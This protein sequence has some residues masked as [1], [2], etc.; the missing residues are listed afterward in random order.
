MRGWLLMVAAQAA[1][2]AAPALTE[3]KPRG[4]EIG[5]PFTLTVIGRNLIEGATVTSTLPAAFTPVLTPQSPGSMMYGPGRTASFLVEL[6]ADAAPGVYPIRVETPSGLSN[7]LLF[8]L[9]TYPETQEEESAVGSPPHRNDSIETAEPVRSTPVVVNGTLRGAERDVFRVYGKAGERRVFEVEAR[10][11]GSAVDPV[12]RILDGTGKQ[13]AR[14]DDSPGASLDARLDFAFPAEGNYYVEIADARFS[15]QAH[16]FYRLKMGSYRYAEGI[17][18][19]GG[20]RGEQTQVTFFGTKLGTAQAVADLRAPSATDAFGKVALPDSPALPFVFAIGDYPEVREPL[21]KAAAIP[22]TINGRLD[23]AGEVDRYKLAVEP[24]DKLILEMQARELGTSKIEAILTAYDAA[25]KKLGSAGDQPL[26]EDVFAVQNSSRTS[27]DP[28]LNI[29]VPPDV[30]ELTVTVEDLALRGGP[31]YGYRLSARKQ[32]EDFKLTI[33]TPQVN[34]PAGGS[35]LVVATAD[36]RGFDGPIQLTVANPPKGIQVEGGFIPREYLDASNQRT[37]NRRGIL[38]ITADSDTKLDTAQLE[39]WGEGR[40]SDGAVLKRRARGIGMSLDVA[41]AT[42]QGVVDRQRSLTAPWLGLDLPVA[43][44]EQPSATLAVRQT[45][46]KPMEEGVRYEYAWEWTIRGSLTPPRSV[47]VEVP[48]AKDLR[49]IDMKAEK[50]GGTFAVTTTKATDPAKYDLYI[51]GRLRTD[52]GDEVIV[53]RPIAF[54]VT[55]GTL[56]A[57]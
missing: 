28:F 20:R 57:K 16:N 19:L 31:L 52:D 33:A 25:G 21:D 13:L 34:I 7:I 56:S 44:G 18:P 1:F 5:R 6:K 50:M 3:L 41:G 29:T 11:A 30:R 53:S 9:G 55:G 17:F 40:A 12:I 26:V 15:N 48:G 43:I 32:S 37:V 54:E 42:D 24:G 36:R 10:R 22:V 2:A 27:S 38:V 4:A 49:I 51:N 23:K 45:A 47:G 46:V 14:S 35:A 8:T 39:V